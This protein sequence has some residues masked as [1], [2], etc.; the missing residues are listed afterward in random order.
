VTVEPFRLARVLDLRGRLRALRRLEAEEAGAACEALVAQ[1]EALRVERERALG[2][3]AAAVQDGGDASVV[4]LAARFEEAVRGRRTALGVRL[5]DARVRLAERRT[6]LARER[7]EERKLEHLAE[8]HRA[9]ADAEAARTAER[10]I[11]ELAASR[12]ATERGER[13]RGE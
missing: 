12:H 2:A 10:L 4:A 6:A 11:D 9:R 3:L 13:D 5:A 8:R 7:R 1:S